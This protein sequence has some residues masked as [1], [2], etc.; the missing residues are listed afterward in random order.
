M[1]ALALV[2]LV[3]KLV[4]TSAGKKLGAEIEALASGSL[5]LGHVYL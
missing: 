3:L 1:D 4:D 5:N 2:P